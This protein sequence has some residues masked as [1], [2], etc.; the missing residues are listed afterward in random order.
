MEDVAGLQREAGDQVEFF[1][2]QHPDNPRF[3]Y[4]EY[5]PPTVELEPTPAELRGKIQAVGR[6]FWSTSALRGIAAVLDD[7]K[8]DVV[9]AHNIYHHLSPSVLRPA[10]KRRVPVVMTLHDYKLA[11]P[12]YLFMDH[13]EVCEAC[14]GGHFLQAPL[15]RCKDDSRLKSGL[16]AAELAVHTRLN[17]YDPVDL[18]LC[19][20]KFMMDKMAQA[21][22]YRSRL[23]QL[24]NFVSPQP[25]TG[26][27]RKS[28]VVYASRLSAEKGVDVLIEA[29]AY[30]PKGAKVHIAGEGP[31]RTSLEARAHQIAPGVVQF[32]GRLPKTEVIQLMR[33][34]SVVAVPSRCYEN[35]PLTVLEA[36]AQ[37]VAVVGSDLGG[38]AELIRH[39][40]NGELV[41]ANN[42]K[43]LGASLT[44]VLSNPAYATK[45]GAA[46]RTTA[47]SEHHP[48]HHLV[49]L[50]N[51]YR[52]AQEPKD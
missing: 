2:M 13:G 8:P 41:P 37:G 26:V 17:L 10:A 20:S 31:L 32:H 14:L 18:F 28:T 11:C 50:G 40:V 51:L 21:G 15:R 24:R 45:L 52:D 39:R 43:A 47:L 27:V 16:L 34:A 3:R 7:F 6:M 46:G 30:L 44:R 38:T 35:Q 25:A 4:E 29:S 33:S 9:H 5:F 23:R 19:P 42:P 22:V 48:D 49:E 1:G 36:F 12:T